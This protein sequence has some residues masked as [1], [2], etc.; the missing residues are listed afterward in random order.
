M[1]R[2]TSRRE[3]FRAWKR[4]N[5]SPWTYRCVSHQT[6]S[7]AR[8]F[9]QRGAGFR[10]LRAFAATDR[11][12]RRSRLERAL[13]LRASVGDEPD[14][15]PPP[16]PPDASRRRQRRAQH[17][18]DVQAEPAPERGGGPGH[19]AAGRAGFARRHADAPP[20]PSGRRPGELRE[21]AIGSPRG[22]AHRA[23]GRVR[24]RVRQGEGA[25]LHA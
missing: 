21:A 23:H 14:T 25:R 24:G 3:T 12:A 17:D 7:A 5:M 2:T 6:R 20:R 11:V 9:R 1:N 16:P 18:G 22:S 4:K 19:V 15:T 10:A 8:G 13:N